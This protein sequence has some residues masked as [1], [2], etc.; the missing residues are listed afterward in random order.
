MVARAGPPGSA[1][2]AAPDFLWAGS[3]ARGRPVARRRQQSRERGTPAR[4][5]GRG[6]R[7]HPGASVPVWLRSG[8]KGVATSF[9]MMLGVFPVLTIA[10][11]GSCRGLGPLARLTRMVGISSP[12]GDALP[13]FVLAALGCR[14]RGVRRLPAKRRAAAPVLWPTCCCRARWRRWSSPSTGATRAHDRGHGR[15]IGQREPWARPRRAPT[16]AQTGGVSGRHT[17]P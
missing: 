2:S 15:R 7:V 6:D 12:G 9:G 17:A 10:V 8:G 1:C 14:R 13:L 16:L 11:L 4:L 5:A 3:D